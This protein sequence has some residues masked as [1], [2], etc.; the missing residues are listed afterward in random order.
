MTPAGVHGFVLTVAA[1]LVIALS[2]PAEDS[3][4]CAVCVSA[5][6][7]LAAFLAPG[8]F[9]RWRCLKPARRVLLHGVREPGAAA[10]CV[11]TFWVWVA[12]GFTA[13]MQLV[14]LLAFIWWVCTLLDV[15]TAVLQQLAEQ[16]ALRLE[17]WS[18]A[19]SSAKPLTVLCV[20]G[21]LT[22]VGWVWLAS[23]FHSALCLVNSVVVT[24]AVVGMQSKDS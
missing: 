4:Q 3:W 1:V 17:D 11:C 8:R 16:E 20:L 10:L 9:L 5:L 7:G 23:G 19:V 14:S 12:Q 22:H 13:S 2:A 21:L 18:D 6:A 24:R 15:D